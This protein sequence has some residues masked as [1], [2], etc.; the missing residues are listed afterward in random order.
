M[1]HS[2]QEILDRAKAMPE[3]SVAVA[4]AHDREVLEA[5]MMAKEMGV[6]EA[7]LVG[8]QAQIE[9]ML[10]D[11]GA[12]PEA[13]AIIDAETDADCAAKAVACVR[14]GG[15][16]CILKGLIGT[17]DLMRAVL[18]R[19][20]GIRKGALLSHMMFYEVPGYPKL[21]VNTDGGLNTAP[22]LE[23]KEV[24]LENAAQA[25]QKLGY[26]K[27]CA[28]CICGAEVVNPKIVAMTDA[29]AL[30][31]MDKWAQYNMEVAGPI[32]LDLA[33]SPAAC[34]HKHFTAPGAGE[35]DIL[36]VPTYEV[37]NAMGK[38]LTLFAGAK[39]AGIVVGAKAPILLVS[40]ADTAEAKL[41]SIAL[42]CLLG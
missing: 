34:A 6:A 29:Q 41:A 9:A 8:R 4:A 7:T 24:I 36:L 18:N 20:T 38:A 1:L 26:E 25:L 42:G 28:S 22:T 39:N 13:F 21:L 35:A 16:N 32:S 3:R 2:M 27:I 33:V 12:D 17:G 5:V 14:E 23:Q 15:A 37:G 10:A 30:A 11:L 31:A 40:R 19:E